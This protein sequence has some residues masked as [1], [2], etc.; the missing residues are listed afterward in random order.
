MGR[1][2]L[3]LLFL[4][5]HLNE[6]QGLMESQQQ[7][8]AEYSANFKQAFNKHKALLSKPTV[9]FNQYMLSVRFPR[10]EQRKPARDH[11]CLI[12]LQNSKLF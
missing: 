12:Q 2:V 1:C 7:V 6:W 9:T 10:T 11:V 3:G 8:L 5:G 4:L